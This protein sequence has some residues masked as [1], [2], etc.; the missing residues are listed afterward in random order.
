[1]LQLRDF[2]SPHVPYV[3]TSDLKCFSRKQSSRSVWLQ[4]NGM[5]R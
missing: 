3:M 2:I 1:M 4:S 5:Q